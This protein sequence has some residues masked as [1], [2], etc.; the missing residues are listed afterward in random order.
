MPSAETSLLNIRHLGEEIGQM[1]YWL[2]NSSSSSNVEV[3][4]LR[5][6]IGRLQGEVEVLKRERER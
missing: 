1:R 2:G 6:E 3:H 5:A 4:A